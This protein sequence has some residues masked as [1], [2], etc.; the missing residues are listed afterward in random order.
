VQAS[1]NKIDLM[2]TEAYKF[3][4]QEEGDWR[5]LDADVPVPIKPWFRTV[6]ALLQMLVGSC[7]VQV[8]VESS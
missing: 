1:A 2:K 3:S 6:M 4:W 8:V 5:P 7:C